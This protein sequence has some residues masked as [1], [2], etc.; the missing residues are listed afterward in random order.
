MRNLVD[1]LLL[2]S[3]MEAGEVAMD[4]EPLDLGDVLDTCVER[5][6]WRAER[7]GIELA[8]TVATD[9]GLVPGDSRRLEQVFGNL[10]DNALRYTPQGGTVTVLAEVAPADALGRPAISGMDAGDQRAGQRWVRVRVHN[11]GSYIAPEELD[12]VFERFYRSRGRPDSS[13]EGSGLGLAIVREIVEAHSGGVVAHSDRDSGTEFEVTLPALA[14]AGPGIVT[15]RS[16]GSLVG[17]PGVPAQWSRWLKRG[18]D[19]Q[20]GPGINGT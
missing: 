7:Q 4:R 1:D 13:A 12:H 5:F 15:K 6:R 2:L 11:T 20:S 9:L 19:G 8:L 14:D 16:R 18:S 3:R 10:L 17:Q